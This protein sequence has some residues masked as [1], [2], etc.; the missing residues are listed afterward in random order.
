MKYRKTKQNQN[1]SDEMKIS[2]KSFP[3]LVNKIFFS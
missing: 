2:F 3:I 1:H